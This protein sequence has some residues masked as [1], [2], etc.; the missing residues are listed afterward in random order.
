MLYDRRLQIG[1]RAET[2]RPIVRQL[3]IEQTS[4]IN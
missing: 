1:M 2:A 3:A 4:A